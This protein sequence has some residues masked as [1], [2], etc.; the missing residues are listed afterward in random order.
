MLPMVEA[1]CSSDGVAIYG[2]FPVLLTTSCLPTMSLVDTVAATPLQCR[3][4]ANA[5]AARCRRRRQVPRLDESF[6]QGVPAAQSAMHQCIHSVLYSICRGFLIVDVS[7]A[8]IRFC[9]ICDRLRL[10]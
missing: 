4:Q 10:E 5:P 8:L 1:R 3:A 2:V 7:F 9:Q 6:V